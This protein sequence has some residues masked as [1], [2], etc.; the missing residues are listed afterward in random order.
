[1]SAGDSSSKPLEAFAQRIKKRP[2]DGKQT[3]NRKN[4]KENF[5]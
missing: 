3:E 1:M 2:T 4:Q 5:Q